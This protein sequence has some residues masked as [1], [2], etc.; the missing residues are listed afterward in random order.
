MIIGE[1]IDVGKLYMIDKN[2]TSDFLQDNES[3]FPSTKLNAYF[4][5]RSDSANYSWHQ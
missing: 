5:I 2:L 3:E 4:L 1:P